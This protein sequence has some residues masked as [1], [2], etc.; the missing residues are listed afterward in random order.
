M[1]ANML[2][3]SIKSLCYMS[4]QFDYHIIEIKHPDWKTIYI[5]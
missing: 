5:Y 4:I 1:N 2:V 3:T